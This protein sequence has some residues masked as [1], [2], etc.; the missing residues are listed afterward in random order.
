MTKVVEGTL[1]LNK[2]AGVAA[3]GGNLEVGDDVP[4][5]AMV[6]HDQGNNIPDTATVTVKADGLYRLFNQTEAFSSLVVNGGTAD[7]NTGTLI[8]SALS[9]TGGSLTAAGSGQVQLNGNVTPTISAAGGATVN[10]GH[11]QMGNAVRTYTVTDGPAAV[12]LGVDSEIRGT[13]GLLKSGPGTMALV[14]GISNTYSGPTTVSGGVLVL[15]KNGRV[16]AAVA[17]PAELTINGGAVREEFNDQIADTAIV[18]VNVGG[19]FDLNGQSDTVG[20]VTVT[21]GT[22]ATSGLSAGRLTAGNTSFNA[23]ATLAMKLVDES[24]SDRITANGMVAVGGALQLNL[25]SAVATGTAITLIDN[26]GT[27]AVAGTFNGLPEG[28]LVT[29]GGQTFSISYA[30]GTGNDVVLTRVNPPQVASFRVND[31][32]AQRSMVTSLTVTFSS[33][34]TLGTGASTLVPQG[35]GTPVALSLTTAVVNGVTVATITFPGATGGSL[36]DGRY[37]LTTVAAHVRDLAG[38]PMAAD[39]QDALFRLFGDVNGDAA[40]NGLDLTEFRKAFGSTSADAAYVSALDF[41]GDGVI[42]GTD[43]TQFRSRFG[44]ILP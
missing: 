39:R 8:I 4:G 29:I 13:A 31:G 1:F 28:A 34:V 10:G 33:Q 14:G 21:G 32:S 6:F 7:V 38:T 35:G 43:L 42:N 2:A 30:G 37:V 41:N 40:V 16:G 24:T 17:V 27:D 25:A 18:N 9:M 19:R 22:L 23:A 3:F 20:P 12:D 26:D 11:V 44:V 5:P 15:N 36:A